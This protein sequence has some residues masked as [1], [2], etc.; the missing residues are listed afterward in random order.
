MRQLLH[1]KGVSNDEISIFLENRVESV[2]EANA[3]SELDTLLNGRKPCVPD[4]SGLDQ[5]EALPRLDEVDSPAFVTA[6]QTL[7][8]ESTLLS[9]T[10]PNMPQPVNSN[11]TYEVT[12]V[13]SS[14]IG[15][16]SQ[17]ALQHQGPFEDILSPFDE[18]GMDNT[19]SCDLAATIIASL[20]SD[21]L[22]VHEVKSD[23]GCP[24]MSNCQI[25]NSTLLEIMDRYTGH[26]MGMRVN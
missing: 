14:F 13:Q 1:V 17:G 22:S 11:A 10:E 18:V 24:P 5:P 9:S 23:L 21:G 4:R 2:R 6:M 26:E 12:S 3:V 7:N 8:A 15:E 25:N 19:L 20:R 16:L